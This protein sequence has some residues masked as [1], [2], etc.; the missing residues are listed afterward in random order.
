MPARRSDLKTACPSLFIRPTTK[1]PSLFVSY[2][3]VGVYRHRHYIFLDGNC[4]P[5]LAFPIQKLLKAGHEI[6]NDLALRR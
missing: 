3:S 4:V 1:T 6:I 5:E 2:H